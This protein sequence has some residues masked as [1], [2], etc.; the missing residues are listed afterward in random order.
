MNAA[1]LMRCGLTCDYTSEC[2][3]FLRTNFD[4][5]DPDVSCVPGV[6]AEFA[7]RQRFLFVDGYILSDSSQL[8]SPAVGSQAPGSQ[9]PRPPGVLNGPQ[10]SATQLVYEEIQTPEPQL[11]CKFVFDLA[12]VFSCLAFKCLTTDVLRNLGFFM[13]TECTTC[14]RRPVLKRSGRS[15]ERCRTWSRR[16]WNVCESI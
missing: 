13:A 11:A 3:G 9:A 1:A 4:I 12:V 6:L 16:C 15:W 8:P 2:L 14:A 7:K 10:R 5:E